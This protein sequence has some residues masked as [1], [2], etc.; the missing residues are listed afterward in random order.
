MDI[1]DGLSALGGLCLFLFGMSIMAEALQRRAGGRLGGQLRR[2]TR[3]RWA[4]FFT[5]LAVT[6][7]VQSSSAAM[8]MVVGF[9][10]SGLLTLGQAVGVIM[11]TNVGTTVTPWLLS[12]GGL[13]GGGF[14]G[15]LLRPA[16]FVPLL[17]L[18]GIIAYLSRN[19]RRRDTG[20]ALLGF[21]T[22]MQGMELMSGSVAGLAQAEGFRRL[23]TAFT[24]PLLGLLAGAVLT[25]VIQSSSASVGILQALAASGQVTVGAAVPIIMGQNIGTCITAMLS[26]VGASR[27][28]RRAA[29]VHLLFNLTGAGVWLAVFWLVKV[30]AAPT[31]LAR[32]VTLPGVAVIHTAFNLLCTAALFP[33]AGLLERAVLRLLPGEET[34][35]AEPDLRLLAAP[36]AALERCRELTLEMADLAR[37]NLRRGIQAL[38][39]VRPDAA[40]ELRRQEERID[41]LEDALGTFLVRLGGRTLTRRDSARAAELLMLMG[42]L[43]RLGDHAMNRLESGEELRDRKIELP[44]EDRRQLRVLTEAVEEIADLAL[45]AFRR[46]D[47]AALGQVE[48]LEQ[49][50]DGLRQRLR[51]RRIR[52]TQPGEG[53]MELSFV[54]SDVLTDLERAADHCCNIMECVADLSAGNRNLH[55]AQLAVRQRDPAFDSRVRAY[56]QKYRI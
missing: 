28:A 46:E 40:R 14:P 4:G 2:M 33:A 47:A 37:D 6:A 43:E 53:A 20:Q 36:A 41:G 54:W 25:A 30:L 16:G 13:E 31:M 1:F 35:S 39:E 49:V 29:L 42:D 26:S 7:A 19:G 8:V 18:W 5:G 24:D 15:R 21:A 23:F 56:E 27:N 48:A 44:P 11:G 32:P 55:A 51:A 52:E 3:S 45:A 22:L 9:V 38:T 17:S 10:N 12:L 50:I 34:P